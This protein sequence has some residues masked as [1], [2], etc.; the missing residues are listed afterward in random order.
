MPCPAAALS[1]GVSSRKPVHKLSPSTPQRLMLA[2]LSSLL[3][4]AEEAPPWRVA[5]F[6]LTLI[7]LGL[8]LRR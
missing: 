1:P 3:H 7:L 2:L 6:L 4:F 8:L 5:G